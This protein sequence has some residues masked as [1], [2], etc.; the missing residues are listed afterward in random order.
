M[1][2]GIVAIVGRP[3]VGKS[4]L[5]NKLTRTQQAIVDDRP[6][7]TRDRIY[8]TVKNLDDEDQGYILIDTGGFETDD[9]YYQPFSSNIVWAQTEQAIKDADLVLMVFDAKSGL[10]PHDRELVQFLKELGK[11]VEYVVNKVD[12]NEQA[13]LTFEFYELGLE[14][15]HQVSAAHSRGIW[16]MSEIVE[17]RLQEAAELKTVKMRDAASTRIALIGRPNAGKSSILNRI[18]GEDRSLVSEIAGTT[19]DT[20]DTPLVYN[21]QPYLLLD[22]AGIRKKK[23]I[24]DKVEGMSVMRSLRTLEDADVV[25]L[26]VDSLEGLS[27]QDCKLAQLAAAKF[28]PILIVVNKWD[29]VPEKETN[30]AKNYEANIRNKLQDMPFIP[31]LF[32][33]CLENQRIHKIMAKVE[34]LT[35]AYAKRVATAKINDCMQR[36]IQEHTPALVKKFNKRVKFYFATQVAI[37]PPTIVVKCNVADEIQESYKRYMIKRFRSELEYGDVPLRVFFRDK[38]DEKDFAAHHGQQ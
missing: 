11:K 37:N 28:K 38:A 19:R 30:T 21:K 15:F 18:C 24:F 22:T 23:N 34:E 14:S 26:V 20:I 31:V 29:L 6:G 27:E 17:A 3:N 7:V 12:G 25:I 10:H 1:I 4:T 33:S 8:G 35:A 9:L 5:F 16:E 13:G 36:A 32:A 2:A